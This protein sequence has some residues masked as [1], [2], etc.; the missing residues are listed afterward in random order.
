HRHAHGITAVTDV[1]SSTPPPI[2]VKELPP[3]TT[4][5]PFLTFNSNP[6]VLPPTYGIHTAPQSP[7]TTSLCRIHPQSLPRPRTCPNPSSTSS[8]PLSTSHSIPALSA[9]KAG[10]SEVG[11]GPMP[12]FDLCYATNQR[13]RKGLSVLGCSPCATSRPVR[14]LCWAG[15]GMMETWCIIYRHC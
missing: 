4:H 6:Q 13:R 2:T 12:S 8:A 1:S 11:A 3:H 15:S 14:R 10:S 7:V 5:N 9:T